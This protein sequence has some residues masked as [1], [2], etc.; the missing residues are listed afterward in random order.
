MVYD[1]LHR[2]LL[3][4]V[5]FEVAQRPHTS[6]FV[7]APHIA[8]HTGTTRDLQWLFI[9]LS[10][11]SMVIGIIEL[12]VNSKSFSVT[13]LLQA[14]GVICV[15]N[16]VQPTGFHI[17]LL[18]FPKKTSLFSL[19]HYKRWTDPLFTRNGKNTETI[20][21]TKRWQFLAASDLRVIGYSLN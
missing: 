14:S 1:N 11:F 10:G 13:V 21:V 8:L 19:V 2:L 3:K 4:L 16:D 9:F 5:M 6:H 12:H 15:T 7:Q 17:L 20:C 18:P